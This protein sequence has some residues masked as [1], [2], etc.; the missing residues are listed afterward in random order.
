MELELALHGACCHTYQRI[1]FDACGALLQKELLP[2]FDP[3]SETTV[4]KTKLKIS[5]YHDCFFH[6]RT[7]KDINLKKNITEICI[8]TV[9]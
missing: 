9:L 3:H 5:T 1:L 6:A 2:T 7:S 8:N 4:T